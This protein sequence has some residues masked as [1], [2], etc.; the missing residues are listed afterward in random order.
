MHKTL[1][2]SDHLKPINLLEIFEFEFLLRRWIGVTSAVAKRWKMI[3]FNFFWNLICPNNKHRKSLKSE[4][5]LCSSTQ[6]R[7]LKTKQKKKKNKWIHSEPKIKEEESVELYIVFYLADKSVSVV[8]SELINRHRTDRDQRT[9]RKNE[10]T[11]TLTHSFSA[12][13]ERARALA[14]FDAIWNKIERTNE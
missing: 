13:N 10:P 5:T 1:C 2:Q 12:E 4:R 11:P 6:K 9:Q 3:V 8:L 7:N 14:S